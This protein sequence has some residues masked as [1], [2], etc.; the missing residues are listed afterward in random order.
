MDWDAHVPP[1]L[2]VVAALNFA[3]TSATSSHPPAHPPTCLEMA[4]DTRYPKPG[5]FLLY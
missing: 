3:R 1:V 4:M 5:E 2:Y